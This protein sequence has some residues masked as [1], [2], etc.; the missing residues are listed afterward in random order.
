MAR[1]VA[2][3]AV[4]EVAPAKPEKIRCKSCGVGWPCDVEMPAHVKQAR[5]FL[6][7]YCAGDPYW[8]KDGYMLQIIGD[9]LAEVKKLH[10]ARV[11]GQH[12]L[13]IVLAS[14]DRSFRRRHCRR[15]FGLSGG[16]DD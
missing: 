15:I 9:E 12:M 1:I 2:G 5:R 7:S 10:G 8:G 16:G 4:V 6:C 11:A 13:T 14:E 3:A